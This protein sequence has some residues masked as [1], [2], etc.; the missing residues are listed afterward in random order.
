MDKI[1]IGRKDRAD[2]PDFSLTDVAVKTDSGAYSCSIDCMSIQLVQHEGEEMLEV[3]FLDEN[4]PKHTGEKIYFT[5]FRKKKVKSSTGHQQERFVI[6]CRI[7]LFGID[8]VS[9]FSLTRRVEMK[10]PILLGRKLLNKRF[11]IDTSKVNL[12]QKLKAK[13]G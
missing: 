5:E 8:F 7:T 1:I 4:H 2:L 12:S 10:N 11:L 13:G 9:D 6:K 3:I